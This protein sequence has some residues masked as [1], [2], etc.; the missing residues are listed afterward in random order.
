MAFFRQVCTLT[1]KNIRLALFRRPF[2]TVF[3]AF[4]LPV[5]FSVVLSAFQFIYSP[6][7]YYGIS[8]PSVVK[9]VPDAM[10]EA[11]GGRNTLV[12]VNNGFVGGDIDRV[13]ASVAAP[14]RAIGK[15]V[16]ILDNP[17]VLLETCPSTLRG[18][19]VCYAAV[20]F[21][22]SPNEGPGGKWNYTLR[23]DGIFGVR[24]D[25]RKP[26]DAE[27]YLLPLQHAVDFSIASMNG[28]VRESALP[29]EVR[30]YT[31]TTETEDQRR[32]RVRRGYMNGITN[33]LAVVYYLL[34]VGIMYQMV[35]FAAR[36]RESGMSGLIE[37]MM[38]NA[39]RWQPQAAR[40]ISYHLAFDCIYE[41]GWVMVAFGLGPGLFKKTNFAIVLIFFLLAGRATSS[42]AV[43]GA[44][45][46]KKAQLSGISC[47]IISIL[48]AIIAQAVSKSNSATV[49]TLSFL[50]P[51]MNFVF[52][53]ISIARY[54]R[55]G[56]GANI[57]KAAPESPWRLP[58]IVL[59]IF[60]VVHI[61]VYPLLGAIVE[62]YLHGTRSKGR[63]ISTQ[64]DAS[65]PVRLENFSK[66]YRPGW[67]SRIVSRKETVVAVDNLNMVARRGQIMALL[68]ANGS[69]KTTTL[70]AIAGLGKVTRGMVVVDGA[71]GLGICPQKVGVSTIRIDILV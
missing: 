45:F 67:F 15:T 47:T 8:R 28:T 46:F 23:A 66:H 57:I 24:V 61:F 63:Q 53:V 54:E 10:R 49:A 70:D 65:D 56:L 60:S 48:L 13:I 39:R 6:P 22:S 42:F 2:S 59:L 58:G 18:D 69:G 11:A 9:S 4:V 40:L 32:D 50:F 27:L 36:E 1:V 25:T 43:F 55:K 20:V 31:Y 44:S 62:R 34:V 29:G 5:I 41:P 30:T 71:S 51:P 19:S 68:G 21:H 3:R 7:A 17:D 38:P 64:N 33:F 52:F 26:T 37:A 12:F 35:G 14:V 16:T